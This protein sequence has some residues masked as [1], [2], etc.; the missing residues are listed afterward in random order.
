MIE[1]KEILDK[2]SE[3]QEKLED[4]GVIRKMLLIMK[5]IQ[6]TPVTDWELHSLADHVFAL[7]K[8]M[9]NLS[10]LK[11]YAYIKAE[12]LEE[13]HKSKVREEYLALKES[14][15]KITDGLAK[16]QAEQKCDKVKQEELIA[17]H[18]ARRLRDLYDNCSRLVNFTQ[19]KMKT[20]DDSRV[21][22]NIP[23]N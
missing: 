23:H 20:Y 4:Q 19:S 3:K 18:Q 15:E 10:D 13:E 16:A 22:S 17:I 6:D 7:C 21:R 5:R 14:G 2:V 12:A 1:S 8:F 11:E 9:D